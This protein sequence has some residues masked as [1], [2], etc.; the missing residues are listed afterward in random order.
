MVI[1]RIVAIVRDIFLVLKY[2]D[3]LERQHIKTGLGL[4]PQDKVKYIR[5]E[6]EKT[7]AKDV[8]RTS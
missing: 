5:I 6:R 7:K 2:H 1:Q 3:N 8:R 4:Y